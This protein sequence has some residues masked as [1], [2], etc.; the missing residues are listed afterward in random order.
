VGDFSLSHLPVGRVAGLAAGLGLCLLIVFALEER[1]PAPE[2]LRVW[3]AND[4]HSSDDDRAQQG[5]QPAQQP[6]QA[7]TTNGNETANLVD[8][9]W[10]TQCTSCHGAMGKGDGPMGPMLHAPDLT[11]PDWQS[12]VTD[13]QIASTIKSGKDKMPKFDLPDDVIAGLVARI[14]QLDGRS[15]APPE[16]GRNKGG[17]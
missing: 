6:Q 11:R 17:R 4:H 1:P 3:S 16:P 5:G 8:L 13:A 2:G 15:A 9:T 7:P 14:R 10:R 12:Q